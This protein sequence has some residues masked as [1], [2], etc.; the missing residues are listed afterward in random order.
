MFSKSEHVSINCIEVQFR[1]NWPSQNTILTTGRYI[2]KTA[3][4]TYGNPS[5]KLDSDR[6]LAILKMV[7]YISAQMANILK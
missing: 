6:G 2:L 1:D 3:G 7:H 4:T 5:F